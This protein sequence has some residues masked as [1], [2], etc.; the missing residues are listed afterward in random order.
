[1]IKNKEFEELSI[2]YELVKTTVEGELKALIDDYRLNNDDNPVDDIRARI[3]TKESAIEKLRKKGYEENIDNLKLHIHDMV[4]IRIICYSLNDVYKVIDL[5]K[6]SNQFSISSEK[7][8]IKNPKKSGYESYHILI[9][10]EI[11]FNDSYEYIPAEIQIRTKAM[12]FWASL[13]HK[14]G[15]KNNNLPDNIR[16]KM[17]NCAKQIGAIAEEMYSLG[18]EA[19]NYND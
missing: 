12:D 16:N 11:S 18:E 5:I 9:H 10:K 1:M 7:D 14:F 13:E 19:N 8:Y 15:Y 17:A 2:K 6:N 4:G 3:K